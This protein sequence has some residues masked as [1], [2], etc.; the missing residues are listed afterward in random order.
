MTHFVTGDFGVDHY[1]TRTRD[2]KTVMEGVKEGYNKEAHRVFLDSCAPEA[3]ER[4]S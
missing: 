2:A 3:D 1:V 4:K